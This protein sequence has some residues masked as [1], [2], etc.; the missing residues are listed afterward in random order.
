VKTGETAV[1]EEKIGVAQD[2]NVRK[3]TRGI[4]IVDIHV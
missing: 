2:N 3:Q 1:G 4:Y